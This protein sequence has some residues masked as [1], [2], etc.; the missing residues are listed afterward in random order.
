M[1]VSA[2]LCSFLEVLG[3][4]HFSCFSSIHRLSLTPWR[5]PLPPSSESAMVDGLYMVLSSPPP[6]TPSRTF[7][8]PHECTVHVCAKSLQSHLTLCDPTDCS[9]PGSSAHR[10]LQAQ[11]MKWVAMA[12]STGIF[13]SQGS[14][15]SLLHLL[16]CRQILYPLGHLGS[17]PECSG[18]TQ[19]IQDHR[20]PQDPSFNRTCK[21]H[22][23]KR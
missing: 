8:D 12:S 3:E 11:I 13:L 21:V 7:K 14:N 22:F 5:W 18:P 19:I 1:K 10:I 16:H 9:P 6:P 17:P 20:P 2:G 15:P 23:A 4:N